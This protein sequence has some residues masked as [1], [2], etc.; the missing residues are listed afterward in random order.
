MTQAINDE[1]HHSDR[2]TIEAR[3][4]ITFGRMRYVLGISTVLVAAA[5][6]AIWLLFYVPS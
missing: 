1:D 5:F 6:F 4:G 3:Q 2:T